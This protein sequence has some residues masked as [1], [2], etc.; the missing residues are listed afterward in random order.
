MSPRSNRRL[1]ELRDELS[2]LMCEQIESLKTQ[3][4]V[5]LSDEEGRKQ[6]ERLKRIRELSAD[7]LSVL[8]NPS[9]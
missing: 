4:F 3:T 2:K 7:L 9:T 1:Q 5:G 6:E 8:K